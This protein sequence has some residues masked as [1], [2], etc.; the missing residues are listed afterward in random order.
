MRAIWPAQNE[1]GL[2]IATRGMQKLMGEG[3]SHEG[4]GGNQSLVLPES[5][6]F[7]ANPSILSILLKPVTTAPCLRFLRQ[8]ATACRE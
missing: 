1:G 7:L 6:P 2:H 4:K 3:V 5:E 8:K